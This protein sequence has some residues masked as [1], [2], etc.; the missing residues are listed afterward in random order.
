MSEILLEELDIE[1]NINV[2]T[3]K[4]QANFLQSEIGRAVNSAIDIGLKAILPNLIEDQIIDIKNT[5]LENGFS[6]GVKEIINSGID[7]G[8]SAIGSVTGN[9]ENVSQIQLAV[10]NGGILDNISDLLDLTIN[11]AKSKKLID[12]NLVN[13]IRKSKNSIIS[14][15]SNKI[16]ESLTNQIKAVEKIEKYCENWKISYGNKEFSEMEKAYKNIK[17]NLDKIVPFERI[18]NN[19]RKIENIHNL[20]KNNGKNFNISN[21]ELLLAEKLY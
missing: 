2:T 5:I 21:E 19:A 11:F 10:K 3:E 18:I 16:E 14:S 15:I 9:F 4:L 20:I 17:N 8:K 1:K 6:E 13:L 12:N 7:F